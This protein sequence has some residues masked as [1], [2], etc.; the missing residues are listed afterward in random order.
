MIKRVLGIMTIA[1][2][3]LTGCVS[4]VD[5]MRGVVAVSGAV[6]GNNTHL[7][8]YFSD[9]DRH[10]I[11]KHYRNKKSKKHKKTPPGLAKKNRLPPG[12]VKQVKRNGHLPPGLEG[13]GLPE[14]LSGQLSNLPAGY[15][16][17]VVESDI[18]LINKK[19]GIVADVMVGVVL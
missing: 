16:R 7:A 13:R 8:I 17:L 19:T 12:L 11:L 5:D 10:H 1:A 2:V 3:F 9:D 15:V 4:L 14:Q 6:K 18:V